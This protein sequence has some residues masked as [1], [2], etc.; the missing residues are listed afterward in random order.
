MFNK[1]AIAALAAGATLVSGLAFAAPA[2]AD[3]VDDL[4]KQLTATVNAD[5]ELKATMDKLNE[6]LKKDNTGDITAKKLGDDVNTNI[7]AAETVVNASTDLAKKL[8]KTPKGK[9]VVRE[10]NIVE[11]YYNK[12]QNMILGLRD[13][14][15]DCNYLR[16]TLP[17]L[18]AW[19]TE[20]EAHYKALQTAWTAYYDAREANRYVDQSRPQDEQNVTVDMHAASDISKAEVEAKQD[21]T[22]VLIDKATADVKEV[23][24]KLA[25]CKASV[26]KFIGG[27]H[28]GINKLSGTKDS[29]ADK[30]ADKKA[31]GKKAAA[32]LAKT[33]A[34][35]ALAA[36]A[37]SVLAGMGAALRKI[38]H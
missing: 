31:A 14:L 28:D 34:A 35:V 1:K 26:D 7:T 18:K 17:Q 25:D 6:K 21:K 9:D 4:S 30:K 23:E 29:K 19:L 20:L 24:G 16:H 3:K 22:Q 33:G 37:A 2:M 12:I 11:Y 13:K 32:P 38:R 5:P 36:V 10:L 8:N 27:V 15:G